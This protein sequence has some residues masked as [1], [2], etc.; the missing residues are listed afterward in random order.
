M[1]PS[2]NSLGYILQILPSEKSETVLTY[3]TNVLYKT[4][5]QHK[6]DYKMGMHVLVP[7]AREALELCLYPRKLR[8]EDVRTIREA[9]GMTGQRLASILGVDGAT[10]S[11]WEH[12]KQEVGLWADKSLRMAAVL[13][14]QGALQGETSFSSRVLDLC[15]RLSEE[16]T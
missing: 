16:G 5:K 3:T 9:M 14:V 2:V 15:A 11:R 1:R 12:G 7:K 4:L 8:G 6:W 13:Y 10:L